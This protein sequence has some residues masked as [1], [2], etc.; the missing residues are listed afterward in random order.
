MSQD[1]V[2]GLD[3]G[4]H[5]TRAALVRDGAPVAVPDEQ[6]RTTHASVVSF[7]DSGVRVGNEA[8]PFLHSAPTATVSSIRELL[9]RNHFSDAVK[10]LRGKVAF[11]LVEGPDHGVLVRVRGNVHTPEALA[12]MLVRQVRGY[13]EKF[14]GA[15][16]RRAV[17]AVPSEYTEAQRNALTRA[18][19]LADLAV[20]DV[21]D[22]SSAVLLANGLLEAHG[23]NVF[24]CEMSAQALHAGVLRPQA[25][26]PVVLSAASD[27]HIGGD[28]FDD[29]VVQWATDQAVARFGVDPA[30]PPVGLT[31]LRLAA[32]DAKNALTESDTVPMLLPGVFLRHLQPVEVELTLVRRDFDQ[33][34]LDMLQRLFKV[35]DEAVRSAQLT[36]AQVDHVVLVGGPTCLPL[37][38]MGLSKY[39]KKQPHGG[40]DPRFAVAFG[41]AMHAAARQG[42]VVAAPSVPALL[43]RE[44]TTSGTLPAVAPAAH[45]LAGLL[46][47]EKTGV[48]NLQ[49]LLSRRRSA[50]QQAVVAALA[51][52][53]GLENQ[54]A[55][56]DTGAGAADA[57]DALGGSTEATRRDVERLNEDAHVL[58]MEERLVDEIAAAFHA[59]E[60]LRQAAETAPGS[61]KGSYV[62]ALRMF[63]LH[64]G[65]VAALLTRAA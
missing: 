14:T 44:R 25:G 36:P 62:Q 65:A 27:P 56:L 4:N 26:G 8:R 20:D 17:V 49:D 52:V 23:K 21:L 18:L 57:L 54:L 64:R 3:L 31:R 55:N 11:E 47:A 41:A 1:A 19:E 61:P 60:A 40:A 9:G 42:L 34:C 29:R 43:P 45:D 46:A 58:G 51:R 30:L 53:D 10:E 12:A 63:G 2:L 48:D 15:P 22:H 5:N 37:V 38:R 32:E 50:Y 16:V 6:G 35:F 33:A 7:T 59:L 39:F 24:A 28:D 13:A